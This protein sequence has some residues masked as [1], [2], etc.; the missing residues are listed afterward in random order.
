MIR[1]SNLVLA[2]GAHQ[3]DVPC[4]GA[5]RLSGPIR[6]LPIRLLDGDS[7]VEEALRD[8]TLNELVNRQ[9]RADVQFSKKMAVEGRQ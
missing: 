3:R 9:Q 2:R 7:K 8:G 6:W 5:H 4:P 1:I